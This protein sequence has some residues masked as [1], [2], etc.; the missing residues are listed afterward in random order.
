MSDYLEPDKRE[1]EL[2]QTAKLLVYVYTQLG[3]PCNSKLR[4]AAANIYCKT[5]YVATLCG[6]LTAFTPEQHNTITYNGRSAESRQLADWWD[7]HQ[8]ADRKR[9]AKEKT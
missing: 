5:D 4:A 8:E 7:R 6:V 3:K 9:L 1:R 2:Q